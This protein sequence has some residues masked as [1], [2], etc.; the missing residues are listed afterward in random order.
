[1][2]VPLIRRVCGNSD[3]TAYTKLK[4]H[5]GYSEAYA[6]N[7][8][9]AGSVGAGGRKILIVDDEPDVVTY[10]ETFFNDH[11]FTT[12]TAQDGKVGFAKAQTEHPDL[13]TLDISMPEES[14][15]KMYRQ[16]QGDPSTKEIPVIIVTGISSDF[17]RFI[18]SRKQVRPPEGYFEKPID[19]EELLK[20][21]QEILGL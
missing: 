6:M 1:M 12:I 8:Q 21:V 16:L 9:A 18:R 17:E 10:L 11:G 19:N 3:K 2:G 14:G 20:K 13:I 4:K 15:V 7:D 5:T